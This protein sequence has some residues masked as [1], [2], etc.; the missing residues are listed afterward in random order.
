[1]QA[2]QAMTCIKLERARAARAS[3]FP[4][5]SLFGSTTV[6]ACGKFHSM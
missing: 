3:V 6:Q 5:L 1:V 4:R 2:G